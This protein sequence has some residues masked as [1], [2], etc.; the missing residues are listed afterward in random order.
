MF[1]VF[2]VLFLTSTFIVSV[3]GA[4]YIGEYTAWGKYFLVGLGVAIWIFL[5]IATIIFW[6]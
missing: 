3:I 2:L 4:V 6:P 1:T 5:G